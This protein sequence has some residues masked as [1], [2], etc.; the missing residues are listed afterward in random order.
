MY[1]QNHVSFHVVLI[2]SF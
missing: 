1:K 2:Y